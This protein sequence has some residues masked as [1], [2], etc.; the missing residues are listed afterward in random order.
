MSI[1]ENLLSGLGIEPELCRVRKK[2]DYVTGMA[3]FSA[4][5]YPEVLERLNR[6]LEPI[7]RNGEKIACE[8]GEGDIVDCGVR[9]FRI[10]KGTFIEVYGYSS[11]TAVFIRLY[12][13]SSEAEEWLALYIDENPS[14]PWWGGKA[15][16]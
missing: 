9:Q 11:T 1:T 3:R 2:G 6:V 13:I 14:T 16:E 15:D 7:L 5:M 4:S 12:V 8:I 10:K